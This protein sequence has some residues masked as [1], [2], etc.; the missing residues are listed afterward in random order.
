[1]VTALRLLLTIVLGVASLGLLSAVIGVAVARASL[2]ASPCAVAE[3]A[4][5]SLRLQTSTHADVVARL[6]CDGIHAIVI[7]SPTIRMERVVW[8]GDAWPYGRFEA[9]FINGVLHGTDKRWISLA[10]FATSG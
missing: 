7:D 1:M 8:R 3:P 9:T 6:G 4:V 5:A 2:P 10:I